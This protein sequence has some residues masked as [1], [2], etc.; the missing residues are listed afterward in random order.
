MLTG[1][2]H[3]TRINNNAKDIKYVAEGYSFASLR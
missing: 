1:S 3:Y 2:R